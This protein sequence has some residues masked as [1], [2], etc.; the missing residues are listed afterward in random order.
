LSLGTSALLTW[1]PPAP[2]D[3]S[4]II[5]DS[6]ESLVSQCQYRLS[7]EQL[8]QVSVWM[9][10]GTVKPP[11]DQRV[12]DLL[13]VADDNLQN[14]GGVLEGTAP[15]YRLAV[16]VEICSFRTG[17]LR[18]QDLANGESQQKPDLVLILMSEFSIPSFKPGE[19]PSQ[20][21]EAEFLIT[22][23]IARAK[24][25]VEM[26]RKVAR[27]VLFCTVPVERFGE[28]GHLGVSQPRTRS[29]RVSAFNQ[30]AYQ[31][32]QSLGASLVDVA[33]LSATVGYENWFD[34]RLFR[35]G[36]FQF[37]PRMFPLVADHVLRVLA[38]KLSTNRRVLVLDL[39]N[40]FWGGVLGDDG[41]DGILVGADDPTSEAFLE[42]QRQLVSLKDRG[43]IL[44]I[45]SKNYEAKVLEALESHPELL[46]RRSD[47]AVIVA[48]WNDKAENLKQ[49]SQ[50]LNLALSWFV[51]IDDSIYERERIRSSLPAV[52]VPE[53]PN[54]PSLYASFLRSLGCFE[55]VDITTEDS[56]RAL[57]L[58][59]VNRREELRNDF[60]TH[61]AFLKS[62]ETVVEVE[63]FSEKVRARVYQLVQKSN[64]FNLTTIRYSM[65]DLQRIERDNSRIGLTFRLRDRLSDSG[66]IAVI[67][68]HFPEEHSCEIETW[69]MSCRVLNRGV[70]ATT[71][72]EVVRC[73]EAR[74]TTVIK[75]KF[76]PT[77]KNEMVANLYTQ[78]G[79]QLEKSGNPDEQLYT[80]ELSQ[81]KSPDSPIHIIR[82]NY[83][84][85]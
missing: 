32:I 31:N 64:Q 28:A 24:R 5:P 6:F 17:D 80:L 77:S 38:G 82:E 15:R 30:W 10:S 63:S 4:R 2:E 16:K 35:I 1:L 21:A 46:L 33:S 76:R 37:S 49:I 70:E 78:F 20:S 36:R 14:L 3:F 39:D 47:F 29:A 58:A 9:Q 73:A 40:T 50:K 57:D 56:S 68:L 84:T 42:F 48:N 22:Q 12:L 72:R 41:L 79:F 67:V 27:H 85:N 7:L 19:H 44:A 11:N 60:S 59:A 83:A 62:L 18:L 13:V 53:L 66:L 71:M 74:G 52:L 45:C 25:L 55:T 54:D 81:F 61:E 23:E 34:E 75:G 69:L 51:F 26:S 8:L 43:V 65:E